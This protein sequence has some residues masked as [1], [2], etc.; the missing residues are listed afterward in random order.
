MAERA[1]LQ[2]ARVQLKPAT[3]MRMR[4]GTVKRYNNACIVVGKSR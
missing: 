1:C 2:G 3:L 4:T